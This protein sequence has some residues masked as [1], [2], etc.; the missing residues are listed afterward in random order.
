MKV[1]VIQ[2]LLFV[3]VL[4]FSCNNSGKKAVDGKDKQ[5]TDNVTEVTKIVGLASIEPLTRIVSLFSDAGGIV[6]KIN[7]DIGSEVKADEPIFKLNDDVEEAQLEQTKSKLATQQ[8]M[9]NSAFA[10]LASLKAKMASSQLTYNRNASLVKAGAVTQ[11]VTDDSKFS[12]ESAQNDALSAEASVKEQEAKKSE[13]E[14]DI[15]YYKTLIER[16]RIKAPATGKV[17]SVDVNIGSYVMPSQ[18]LGNFAP[19]GPLMAITEVDELFAE[20]VKVGMKAYI[21]TEGQT[22]TLATGKVYLTS[23]YLR[24]KTL[25]SDDATNMEDRRVREVR[26]LLDKSGELL[27]GSRV[28]CV[29]LLK[30]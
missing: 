14:A 16:K 29:I 8:A 3:P 20:K 2:A 13:I 19:D 4:L 18:S 25:F 11:Q 5:V 26:V 21:R 15:N 10:Q 30:P 9:I 22:D 7:Y 23:P 28:E 24:K 17:L 27:I 1:I 6:E 12:Y